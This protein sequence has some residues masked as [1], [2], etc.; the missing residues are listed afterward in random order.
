MKRYLRNL[1]M[2][3]IGRNPYQVELDELTEHYEKTA[4]R[5]MRLEEMHLTLQMKLK[6]TFK[7]V[8]DYQALVENLRKRLSDKDA[9][10]ED[11]RKEYNMWMQRQKA[12]YQQR[13]DEYN[14]K[15]DE[16]TNCKTQ[17]RP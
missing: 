11:A 4:E 14:A 12:D 15:I 13:I 10:L 7:W 1:L 5:V 17:D 2:A 8:S 9:E 16:L 3:I 6:E